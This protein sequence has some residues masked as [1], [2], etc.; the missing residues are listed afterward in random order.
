[1]TISRKLSIAAIILG[2]LFF[3]VGLMICYAQ[4]PNVFQVPFVGPGLI[5]TG[6]GIEVVGLRRL[7]LFSKKL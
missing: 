3:L 2:E 5:V 7:N 4:W 1:M 6:V